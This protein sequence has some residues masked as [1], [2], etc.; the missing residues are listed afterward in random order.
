MNDQLNVEWR[1]VL[2]FEG[3]YQVSNYGMIKRICAFDSMGRRRKVGLLKVHLNK[4]NQA[5]VP[6][7][8]N[9]KLKL[10]SIARIVLY[11]FDSVKDNTFQAR[12]IDQDFTNNRAD[13]LFW[14]HNS[15]DYGEH[16]GFSKLT[17]V[18]V[19]KIVE[20]LKEQR[21]S[22]WIADQFQISQATVRRIATRKAWAKD[23]AE[24]VNGVIG[25]KSHSR[26]HLMYQL[27][28]PYTTGK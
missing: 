13:N 28:P 10:Y 8:K 22:A 15:E 18:E 7:C 16:N 5:R 3:V 12:H 19:K 26:K 23:N 9:G 6:L 2:D 21:S 1:D 24:I 27:I 11:A 25:N 20:F 14:L 4:R 17:K